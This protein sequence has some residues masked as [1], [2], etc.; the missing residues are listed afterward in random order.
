MI[1][2]DILHSVY[3]IFFVQLHV[4]KA[5]GSYLLTMLSLNFAAAAIL[6]HP[7]YSVLM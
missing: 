5:Y 1:P 3:L 6:Y 2:V 4:G 7:K